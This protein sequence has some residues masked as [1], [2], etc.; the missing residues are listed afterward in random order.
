MARAE[1]GRPGCGVDRATRAWEQ[2]GLERP[3]E[4]VEEGADP[5]VTCQRYYPEC[6]LLALGWDGRSWRYVARHT[7]A[8][9]ARLA[10][11]WPVYPYLPD[12]EREAW[13][14]GVVALSSSGHGRRPPSGRR[15]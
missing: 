8:D 12:D 5:L 1:R 10:A 9:L 15:L 7:M 13:I 14:R 6:G 3:D 11:P 4:V 2:A